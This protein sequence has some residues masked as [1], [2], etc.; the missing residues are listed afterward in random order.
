MAAGSAPRH[1]QNVTRRVLV[2]DDSGHFRSTA[3]ELLT[4]RGLC[5]VAAAADGEEAHAAVSAHGC[6]DGVL[7]DVNLP[8]PD[9]FTVAA[10][11]ALVCPGSR[12]VLTSADVD[13]VPR[14]ALTDCGAVAFV[15]KTELATVDLN[16]LFAPDDGRDPRRT[17][18]GPSSAGI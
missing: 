18:P 8:G 17:P 14:S 6:P 9:G 5:P 12:I 11:L 3:A 16:Q 15:P 1:G 10:S 7:L 4:M 2:V 13:D